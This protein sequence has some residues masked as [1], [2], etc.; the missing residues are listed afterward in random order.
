MAKRH[1]SDRERAAAL[2]IY[3]STADQAHRLRDAA[4]Q[5]GVPKSTLE[6]WTKA[7]DSAAPPE[8]RTE[9]KEAL[10]DVFRRVARKAVMLQGVALEWI[11]EQGGEAAAKHLSDLNRVGGTAVDKAQLLE[12]NATE[13]LE[14]D[15]RRDPAAVAGRVA[16][17]LD[18]AKHRKARRG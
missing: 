2:A 3:D 18:L 14:V 15:D 11:E 6:G 12:G 17:I 5:A 8:V 7:R 1:Y 10:A 9:E 13:R 16:E 4:R